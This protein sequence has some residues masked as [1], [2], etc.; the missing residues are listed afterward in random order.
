M[1]AW[2]WRSAMNFSK[3]MMERA[4]KND[5]KTRLAEAWSL[6]KGSGKEG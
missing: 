2:T 5:T 1:E 6:Y 3:E 4:K